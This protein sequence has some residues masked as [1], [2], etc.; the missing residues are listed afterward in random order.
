MRVNL[1]P[2]LQIV[3]EMIRA[4]SIFCPHAITEPVLALQKPLRPC[5]VGK[6]GAVSGAVSSVGFHDI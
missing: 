6:A 3:R 2:V 4:S 5:S 1:S